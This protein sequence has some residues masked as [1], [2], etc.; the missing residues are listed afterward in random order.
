[1][2]QTTRSVLYLTLVKSG[3]RPVFG[4]PQCFELPVSMRGG[5]ECNDIPLF[6]KFVKECAANAK[7]NA[8]KIVFC[9]E[10]D[11]VVSKEY[12]HLPCSSKNL[13]AS[14]RL[15]AESVL[16][17]N[18]NDYMILNYEYGLPN[19]VTGKLTSSL[20]AAKSKLL[21]Q[22]KKDFSRCGL[23]VIKI[24]PPISGL[25]YAGK[26][27]IDSKNKTVAVLDFGFEKTHL[28]IFHD[29][30]TVFQRSFETVYDDII[31][32]QMKAKSLSY[33]DAAKLVGS[34]GFYGED[35]HSRDL[36]YGKQI[37]MLLDTCINEAIRNIRMVLSSERLELNKLM[38]CGR[39]TTVPG[40][41]A[42]CDDLGLDIPPESV[43]M[44]TPTDKLPKVDSEAK[45]AGCRPATFLTAAGLLAAKKTDDIDFLTMIKAKSGTR[46]FNVSVLALITVLSLC[47]MALEPILYFST[48]NQ[49]ARDKVSLADAKYEQ[50]KDLLQEQSELSAKLSKVE[51][52]AKLL[53]AGKSKAEEPAKQLFLQVGAKVKLIKTFIIDN[54]TG[55]ITLTFL[56][57]NYN[58]YL[59]VKHNVESND[60]FLIAIP[61][62][63][64]IS[65]DGT[66]VCSVTLNVK[67]FVPMSTSSKGGGTK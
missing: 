61:F 1:L 58:D 65:T 46:A 3:R 18:I 40:F 42:L 43:D 54:M 10:D 11:N 16:Q 60:F 21:S 26:T 5:K 59:T 52:D 49:Q 66:C 17:D 29:G 34:Y 30:S 55:S 20:F 2:L 32:I 9:L 22:I 50:V 45:R 28:I 44:C 13:L 19:T 38:L 6:A 41:A 62:H 56:T 39:L 7:L 4:A 25:L 35:S 27:V 15:E 33:H 63:A 31:E 67:G 24:V 51:S 48:L 64:E 36:E 37:S 12:R 53:P 23:H 57:A 14:A 8:K 47:V